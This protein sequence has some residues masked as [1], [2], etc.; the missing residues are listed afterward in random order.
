MALGIPDAAALK[1]VLGRMRAS[2]LQAK[3]DARIEGFELQEELTDCVEV[4]AGF[5]AA[6]PFGALVMV[7]TGGVL[8]ELAADRAVAL[9][10]V[11]P[12]RART[13]IAGTKLGRRLAGYRALMA[14]TE[15]GPL[16]ELV[17]RLSALAADLPGIA[18][19]D[20][21]PVLVRKGSGEARVVDALLV[22]GRSG[23]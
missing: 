18:A 3:P 17:A 11:T 19:C 13:V 7:G 4:A 6:A 21:N 15:I 5:I 20:L 8:V 1:S 2:V 16:A 23:G 9:A 22:A 14:P 10:P 12:E